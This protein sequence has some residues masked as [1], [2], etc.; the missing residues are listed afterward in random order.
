MVLRALAIVSISLAPLSAC[1]APARDVG[2][3]PP[4]AP[5]VVTAPLTCA[6][7]PTTTFGI[8]VSKW[9]GTINWGAVAGDGVEFAFIRVSDGTG[10]ID[11]QFG[12]NWQGAGAQGILRGAYQ[13]FRADE[14]PEAQAQIVLDHLAEHGP[15]ELPAVIDVESAD[16]QAPATVAANVRRWIDV[17]E[18]ETGLAPIIYTGRYFW[19]G[20]V[21][22]TDFSDYPL[23][24][25]QWTSAA[26][27]TLPAGWDDWTF[28][29]YSATGRVAGI[30][31]DVDLD[32]FDGTRAELAALGEAGCGDCGLGAECS[33]VGGEPHCVDLR[34]TVELGAEE[35]TACV[36][37]RALL[38]CTYG[39][40]V[41]SLCPDG[42]TC[43]GGPGGAACDEAPVEPV[44][45]PSPEPVAEAAP[46]PGPEPA[47][48]PA[49]ELAPD[50]I[51]AADAALA[52]APSRLV[53][54]SVHTPAGSGCAGGELDA[55][56][57]ALAAVVL[58]ARR[59]VS[60][61]PRSR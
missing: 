17:V 60:R 12:A 48:E 25:A 33:E 9:Q 51:L 23:W 56:W 6:D 39:V 34:C 13:F 19:D 40:A 15:G 36:G 32:R 18:A 43:Q 1:D 10:Y 50:V 57:L 27:A 16:G 42:E 61:A 20:S 14:D 46:E 7:S 2:V 28:W 8:D 49:V 24:V 37:A 58:A 47:P 4:A 5:G 29:Q 3:E 11:G 26:C 38:T 45:E 22:S 52:G 35:G 55:G 41:E 21:K 31:G 53:R 30:S 44:P 59:R 54:S